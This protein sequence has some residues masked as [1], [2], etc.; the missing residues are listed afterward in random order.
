MTRGRRRR[1]EAARPARA[2]AP[3][4]AA[5]AARPRGVRIHP[6]RPEDLAALARLMADSTLLGRYRTTRA[7]AHRALVRGRRDGDRLLVARQAG[8]GPIGL[9]WVI[10]SRILTGAAY[11]RLLLV[12][13]G[14]QG[15]G[16]GG[17]LLAAAESQAGKA[18]NHLL[19]LVTTGNVGAR[20]FYERRGYR[21]VGDLPG[22]A[23]P[24]LDEA[25]YHKAL[26]PH[27]KRL[28]V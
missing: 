21:H 1:P 18:A 15:R 4:P 12:A 6:A 17:R 10:V 11:L 9:A 20:R 24:E 5:S 25:L 3:R 28:P 23:R 14:L 27:G 19:L 7:G 13:D 16:L 26:R 2:R 22:L 8:A